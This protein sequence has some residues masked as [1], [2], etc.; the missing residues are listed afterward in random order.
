MDH[1]RA[2]QRAIPVRALAFT[3]ALAAFLATRSPKLGFDL[4]LG[5]VTGVLYMRLVMQANERLLDGGASLGAHATRGMIRIG[6]AGAIP[7]F[8][9]VLGPWWGML[10]YFA[11]FFTPYALFVLDVRR[12]W[13][14]DERAPR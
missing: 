12:R 8:A 5:G 4:A 10:V 2:T 6:A 14:K 7:V 3:F 9:A 11:G 1:Y 13:L